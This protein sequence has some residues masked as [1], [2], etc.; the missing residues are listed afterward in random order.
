[1]LGVTEDRAYVNE[2][3]MSVLVPALVRGLKSKC[4]DYKAASYMVLSQLATHT[5]L[6]TDVV[7]SM[8]QVLTKVR[9]NWLKGSHAGEIIVRFIKSPENIKVFTI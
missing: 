5:T 6:Q 8:L 9:V 3:I 1:M 2:K 4:V 7:T